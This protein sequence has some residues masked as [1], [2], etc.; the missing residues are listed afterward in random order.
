MASF[1]S[2]IFT[3][4]G[5]GGTGAGAGAGGTLTGVKA[6]GREPPLPG[7]VIVGGST[8]TSAPFLAGLGVVAGVGVGESSSAFPVPVGVDEEARFP[9]SGTGTGEVVVPG[10]STAVVVVRGGIHSTVT[11]VCSPL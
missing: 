2:K 6:R 3:S 7:A 5:V 4:S 1:N 11:T 10:V 8:A 9:A